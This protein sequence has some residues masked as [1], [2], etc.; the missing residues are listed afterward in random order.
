MTNLFQ[1]AQSRNGWCP[2]DADSVISRHPSVGEHPSAIY[3][4][5]FAEKAQHLYQGCYFLSG[6]KNTRMH[7][8]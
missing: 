7:K 5:F 1:M 6:D 8:A 4:S 2:A 3:L